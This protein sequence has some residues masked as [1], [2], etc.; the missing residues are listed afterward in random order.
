MLAACPTGCRYSQTRVFANCQGLMH[1]IIIDVSKWFAAMWNWKGSLNRW[2]LDREQIFVL[3]YENI[4]FTDEVLSSHVQNGWPDLPLLF[5]CSRTS[6]RKP[7]YHNF[8]DNYIWLHQRTKMCKDMFFSSVALGILTQC[9]K[10]YFFP[11]ECISN[12][13]IVDT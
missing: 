6:Y 4:H 1:L 13:I 11:P 9:W 2:V 5:V 10:K 8:D 3:P 12:I 7:T